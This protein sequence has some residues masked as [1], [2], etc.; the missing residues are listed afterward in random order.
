MLGCL[1]SFSFSSPVS[2]HRDDDVRLPVAVYVDVGVSVAAIQEAN[3]ISNPNSLR[4]GQS[5]RIPGTVAVAER[6]NPSGRL[7]A[8]RSGRSSKRA[9]YTVRPGDNLWNIARRYDVSVDDLK[10]WNNVDESA[11]RVGATMIVEAN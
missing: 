11:L 7:G 2:L 9:T 5:L 3:D 1:V 8:S 10:R 4:A 6:K